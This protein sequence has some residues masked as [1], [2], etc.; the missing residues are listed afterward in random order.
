AADAI[1]NGLRD[2]RDV[3]QRARDDAADLQTGDPEAFGEELQ[4]IGQDVQT[5]LTEV[6]DAM[7]ELESPEVD[8]V[9]EDVPECQELNQLS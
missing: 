4:A 7:G 8:D 1:S 3:L 2:A 9:A 5:S 6:G